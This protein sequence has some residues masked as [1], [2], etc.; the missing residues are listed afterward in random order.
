MNAFEMVG[1]F[2]SVR[3]LKRWMAVSSLSSCVSPSACGLN[4]FF[5]ERRSSFLAFVNVALNY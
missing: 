5:G 2:V 4:M 3:K 1:S